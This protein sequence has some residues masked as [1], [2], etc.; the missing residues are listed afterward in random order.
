MRKLKTKYK[1][2][3]NKV[4][5]MKQLQTFKKRLNQINM[6]KIYNNSKLL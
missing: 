3:I 2:K 6:F 1:T 4:F 5:T